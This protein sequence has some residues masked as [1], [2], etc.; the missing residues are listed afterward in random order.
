MAASHQQ[1]LETI[2]ENEL[3]NV[4]WIPL[5][6][7]I[8]PPYRYIKCVTQT[9]HDVYVDLRYDKNT[10]S[11]LPTQTYID[12]TPELSSS[13][14]LALDHSLVEAAMSSLDGLTTGGIYERPG[15]L[16]VVRRVLGRQTPEIRYYSSGKDVCGVFSTD[17][18]DDSHVYGAAFYLTVNMDD[19][20]Q[21]SKI[22]DEQ[23]DAVVRRVRNL[24][25]PYYLDE[26]MKTSDELQKL[27]S[28]WNTFN[29]LRNFL[30]EDQDPQG[31][32]V[33]GNL[34]RDIDMLMRASR[35]LRKNGLKTDQERM[36]HNKFVFALYLRQHNIIDLLDVCRKFHEV[37]EGLA[38][39]RS[40][41]DIAANT[42]QS[43]KES[44]A[45]LET[46]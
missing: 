18:S 37:W 9:G 6:E 36:N 41:I 40:I 28:S 39:I 44:L 35:E 13:H 30:T 20:R 7:F 26:L 17:E 31:S 32:F 8:L 16:T 12:I 21:D 45:T 5:Q 42:L 24:I 34:N 2:P 38:N 46:P 25:Y 14:K 10:L 3:L 22:V 43:A 15:G 23:V 27:V 33:N 1:L 19:I 29:T 4:N 11:Q